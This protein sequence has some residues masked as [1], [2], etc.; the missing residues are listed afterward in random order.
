MESIILEYFE[1]GDTFEASLALD[2]ISFG[3]KRYM[4]N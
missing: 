3:K 1:H 2:D 4:V